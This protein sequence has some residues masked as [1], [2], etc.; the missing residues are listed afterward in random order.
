MRLSVGRVCV[1]SMR[2]YR[3]YAAAKKGAAPSGPD[4]LV[5]GVNID[6]LYPELKLAELTDDDVPQW[7]HEEIQIYKDSLEGK[8]VKPAPGKE[9]K[10]DY[11]LARRKAIKEENERRVLGGL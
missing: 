2:N 5:D 6:D 1:G 10:R 7:V 3:F 8:Q 4:A 11:K 9:T